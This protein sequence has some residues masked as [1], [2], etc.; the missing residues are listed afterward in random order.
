M[1]RCTRVCRG[2][3]ALHAVCTPMDHCAVNFE[4]L[5]IGSMVLKDAYSRGRLG[6]HMRTHVLVPRDQFGPSLT[7]HFKPVACI[8]GESSS[9][10]LPRPHSHSSMHD[11]PSRVVCTVTM[12]VRG[13]ALINYPCTIHHMHRHCTCRCTVCVHYV[14]GQ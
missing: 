2:H 9:R 1:C 7:C 8:I 12:I 10:D 5:F 4:K 11:M 3:A 6:M 13:P 14:C